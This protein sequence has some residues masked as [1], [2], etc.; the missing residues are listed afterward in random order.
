MPSTRIDPPCR[1]QSQNNTDCVYVNENRAAARIFLSDLDSSVGG[2]TTREV[3][4][5]SVGVFGPAIFAPTFRYLSAGCSGRKFVS[6]SN[7]LQVI[8]K[9]L[10][11]SQLGSGIQKEACHDPVP[12][13]IIHRYLLI[14]GS[15]IVLKI[16]GAT[17]IFFPEYETI[18][19]AFS[20]SPPPAP[21]LS[22]TNTTWNV[23]VSSM[24]G[25][26]PARSPIVSK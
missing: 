14:P 17:V 12:T 7:L 22:P 18:L 9:K 19:S 13:R 5:S 16:H 6:V 15:Q 11:D 21:W 23:R 2:M 3:V 20:V 25:K 26:V 24:P 10:L 1:T 4:Q 8:E